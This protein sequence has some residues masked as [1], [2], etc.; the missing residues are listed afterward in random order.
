M[1]DHIMQLLQER[2]LQEAE[3]KRRFVAQDSTFYIVKIREGIAT[4]EIPASQERSHEQSRFSPEWRNAFLETWNNQESC[5]SVLNCVFQSARP[6]HVSGRP[7]SLPFAS[8]SEVQSVFDT[9]RLPS[10]YFQLASGFAG[11]AQANII[12]DSGG[13]PVRYELIANCLSKQGDWAI[14][15]S[16]D[17]K[18]RVTSV[19]WS[20][21]EKIDSSLLIDDFQ[22]FQPYASHPMLIPCIMF[23]A[24]LR[25]S[26]QRRQSIK[27][28]LQRLETAIEQ[29]N[30]KEAAS[31]G[32]SAHAQDSFEQPQSLEFM[33]QLLHS[34]RKDQTSRKG[35]YGFWRSFVD[36]VESGFGYMEES[37]L[38][39][40]THILEAHGELKRWL[41]VNGNKLESLMARA[42]DHVCRVDDASHMLYSLMEQRDLR[43]QSSIAR[44]AQRD[45]EDMKF[46][47]VLG[48]I[49]LPASLIATIL[50]IPDFQFA[51]G[52]NLFAAYIGITVPLIALVIALCF[53]RSD[54]RRLIWRKS[55]AGI[56][57]SRTRSLRADTDVYAVGD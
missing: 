1:R 43:V 6:P 47:A 2:H 21:D 15:L 19:F 48:S 7:D 11:S 51:A 40:D 50:N 36:A 52:G 4:E 27:R 46:I 9:L 13:L 22:E 45:S 56:R 57:Q 25:M 14:A 37:G 49:F 41:A 30:K 10:S 39:S 55:S 20:V 31:D 16:H 32:E 12:G 42:E 18:C 17:A 5:L 26:E 8:H 23:A 38:I 33:F 54:L 35:R 29:I 34:C 24:S 3:A 44:A 28:N 53:A